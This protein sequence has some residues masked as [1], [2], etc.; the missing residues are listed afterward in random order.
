MNKDTKNIF[1]SYKLISENENTPDELPSSEPEMPAPKL[2]PLP[3][4][5]PGRELWQPPM[6]MD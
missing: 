5:Q 1:E 2:P 3:K 4:P 6:P